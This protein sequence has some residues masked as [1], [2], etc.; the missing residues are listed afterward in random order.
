MAH[1]PCLY[2]VGFKE[3][4]WCIDEC[5]ERHQLVSQL[6]H[7][8]SLVLSLF[9]LRSSFNFSWCTCRSREN[10]HTVKASVPSKLHRVRYFG[11]LELEEFKDLI[12]PE[13][14]VACVNAKKKSST[15]YPLTIDVFVSFLYKVFAYSID[16]FFFSFSISLLTNMW[17]SAERNLSSF[18]RCSTSLQG[19]H[20]FTGEDCNWCFQSYVICGG[21]G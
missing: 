20:T 12:T 7:F 14:Y 11:A 9:S 15:W 17:I 1:F 3:T 5:H 13:E 4:K 19:Q 21:K 10:D 18:G 16:L 8:N 6:L 2:C